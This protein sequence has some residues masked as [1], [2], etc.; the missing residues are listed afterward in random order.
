MTDY[1]GGTRAVDHVLE[2][3]HMKKLIA[4]CM[5]SVTCSAL[6]AADL[7]W[8][9]DAAAVGNSAITGAGLGGAGTWDAATTNWWDG[10]AGADNSWSAGSV[11]VFKGTAGLVTLGAAQSAAGLTFNT[12]GYELTNTANAL[13]LTGTPVVSVGPG[14]TATMS[15]KLAGTA[16]MSVS[17]GG[18]FALKPAT[19]VNS[20][21]GAVSISGGSTLQLS[22]G[23]DIGGTGAGSGNVTLNNGTLRN[24]DAT[25]GNSFL[26]SNR[27]ILLGAGGGTVDVAS[28]IALVYGSG[29]ASSPNGKITGAGNTLTKT[30]PG[31]FR[32]QSDGTAS[33]DFSKLV[34]NQGLFRLGS[35]VVSS[36]QLTSE[37][38]FGAAPSV[39]TPDAIT[40]NN[41]SIGASFGVTLN[42]NRGITLGVN[43]GTINASSGAMTIPGAITGVGALTKSGSNTVTLS[44]VNTFAGNFTI[45]G[46]PVNFD[47]NSAASSGNIIVTPSSATTLRNSVVLTTLANNITLNTGSS[48]IDILAT[49]GNTLVLNGTISG[50]AGFTRGNG[51]GGGTVVLGGNN[52]GWAGGVTLK[53]G[54]LSLGNKNALG[55]ADLKVTPSATGSTTVPLLS[56]SIPLTGANAIANNIKIDNSGANGNTLH[57]TGSND[58]EL[59]GII[60]DGTGGAGAINKAGSSTVSLSGAN[61]YTGGTT[62]TAGTLRIN[63][64]TG[65]ATGTAAVTVKTGG[66]LAGTGAISG[67]V[68]IEGGGTI[69]P[70]NSP[71][72]LNVGAITFNA[73]SIF[74]YEVDSNAAPAS[75]ADLINA[76]G[77]LAIAAAGALLNVTYAGTNLLSKLTLVSYAGAWN[78]NVFDGF[79]DDSV[80]TLGG[81]QYV[82]NYNDVA[83]GVNFG[84]GIYGDGV[85][86]HFLTLTAVPEAGAFVSGCLVCGVIGLGFI[87]RKLFQR[88]A[89]CASAEIAA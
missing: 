84:G 2:F 74:Q 18:L 27:T 62:V 23:G 33:S 65:S 12:D 66:T 51:G 68:T 36:V 59:R 53:Q 7:Y 31:E 63:N 57:L 80:V 1:D 4:I 83:G 61:T 71:G 42:S 50:A 20:M 38:G 41:G 11:A 85:N 52:S 8:D 48:T 35:V 58:F 24:T 15:G 55:S 47:N 89:K 22:R 28:G 43:G 79:A 30:G 70:G 46:G 45:T 75:S 44:G 39:F 56:A 78:G 3:C 9:S 73:G 72:V 6:R 37:L 14:I 21:T 16:G 69:A 77:N 5:L 29:T 67:A 34:V 54:T 88:R 25:N 17:G 76:N 10:V 49:S 87:R 82:I 64:S 32:Y 19:N 40:L 60:S 13:T 26:T 81:N 86:P